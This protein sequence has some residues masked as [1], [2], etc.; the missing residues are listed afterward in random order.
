MHPWLT[1]IDFSAQEL[2]AEARPS[3]QPKGQTTGELPA[4]LVLEFGGALLGGGLL[5]ALG[6]IAELA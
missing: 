1:G 4:G 3:E 6:G 5:A 2:E